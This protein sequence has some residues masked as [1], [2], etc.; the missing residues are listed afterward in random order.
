MVQPLMRTFRVIMDHKIVYGLTQRGLAEQ[1]DLRQG[2]VFERSEEA[3][4]V[5]VAI[6]TLRRQLGSSPSAY[7]GSI[8]QLD[9]AYQ[10][11]LRPARLLEYIPGLIAQDQMGT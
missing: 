4:Q 2:F 1:D 6:G 9:L 10:P 7:Q 5:G 11:I 8:S 3:F